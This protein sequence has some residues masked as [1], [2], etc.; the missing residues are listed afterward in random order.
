MWIFFELIIM[1]IPFRTI[2]SLFSDTN[3]FIS[4]NLVARETF[5][6]NLH[7][8]LIKETRTAIIIFAESVH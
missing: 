6:N 5:S 1:I 3:K 2:V 8:T 7:F 4:N